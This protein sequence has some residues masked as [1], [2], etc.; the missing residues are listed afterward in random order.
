MTAIVDL[1]PSLRPKKT[2]VALALCVVM[3]LL[4]LTMCTQV[5]TTWTISVYKPGLLM[6]DGNM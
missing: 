6:L 4:G 2:F 1:V 5:G 3:Y